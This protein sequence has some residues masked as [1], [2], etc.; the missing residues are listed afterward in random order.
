M[1]NLTSPPTRRRMCHGTPLPPCNSTWEHRFYP[2]N[3]LSHSSIRYVGY[4]WC[5]VIARGHAT[6][7]RC[8]SCKSNF[9]I[10]NTERSRSRYATFCC[11]I[12]FQNLLT[13]PNFQRSQSHLV[14]YSTPTSPPPPSFQKIEQIF[15]PVFTPSSAVRVVPLTNSSA[16]FP[17]T[18]AVHSSSRS[19]SPNILEAP[20]CHL[21]L[22]MTHRKS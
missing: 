11:A 17:P 18:A 9:V 6:N 22:V 4:V 3:L 2:R 12:Y 10:V 21:G 16:L 20:W 14:K 13:D 19:I 7:N 1:K 8:K 15:F 5:S